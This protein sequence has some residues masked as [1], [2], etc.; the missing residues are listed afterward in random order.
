MF[1]TCI[2]E[3]RLWV[4]FDPPGMGDC[5]YLCLIYIRLIR[6]FFA[7]HRS[8]KALERKR[9]GDKAL[10]KDVPLPGASSIWDESSCVVEIDEIDEV[11]LTGES[12]SSAAHAAMHPEDRQQI[13]TVLEAAGWTANDQPSGFAQVPAMCVCVSD[14]QIKTYLEAS[15]DPSIPPT[16]IQKRSER[17]PDPFNIVLVSCLSIG[18]RFYAP[19]FIAL[20]ADRLW[21]TLR[22]AGG[23]HGF[24]NYQI[25]LV[26][27]EAHL[28]K[29]SRVLKHANYVHTTA[30]LLDQD[31]WDAMREAQMNDPAAAKQAVLE[32]NVDRAELQPSTEPSMR[33]M[34][35]DDSDDSTVAIS[36]D[37]DEYTDGACMSTRARAA[38]A[39]SNSH[40]EPSPEPEHE[41]EIECDPERSDDDVAP[42]KLFECSVS[43]CAKS[44]TS[45]RGLRSHLAWHKRRSQSS[46]PNMPVPPGS[47][48]EQQ[49]ACDK[50]SRSFKTQRGLTQHSKF[51]DRPLR[52]SRSPSFSRSRSFSRANGEVDRE[53]APSSNDAKPEE[54]VPASFT[55][56]QDFLQMQQTLLGEVNKQQREIY[57]EANQR[58][59]EQIKQQAERQLRII[60][61]VNARDLKLRELDLATIHEQARLLQQGSGPSPLTGSSVSPHLLKENKATAQI[62]SNNDV[63]SILVEKLKD[64]HM[65]ITLLSGMKTQLISKLLGDIG[66]EYCG[67]RRKVEVAL[68]NLG[69]KGSWN[70]D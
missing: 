7:L 41:S 18:D 19:R 20:C 27:L 16:Q 12:K 46:S 10:A 34:S 37:P 3:G 22:V 17:F 70:A 15:I 63:N 5:G 2:Q 67:A 9:V 28:D 48:P 4:P 25:W 38:A 14:D 45:Q 1:C 69:V 24:P 60:Q 8:R 54:T 40:V 47:T 6:I 33:M 36:A 29:A 42:E 61:E 58:L 32:N 55:P 21:I 50:C 51:H 66:P 30:M 68:T 57:Q 53:Y 64:K 23:V 49:Y 65:N 31:I 39:G 35:A 56:P 62:A 13:R 26:P 52:L 59:D 43:G 44:F 11:D